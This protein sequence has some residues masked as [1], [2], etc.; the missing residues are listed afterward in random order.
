[1][2]TVNST[3]KVNGTS[4]ANNGTVIL[5]GGT[6]SYSSASFIHQIEA[7][8]N[9]GY[10]FNSWTRNDQGTVA[11]YEENSLKTSSTTASTK[12]KIK[13]TATI[14]A[15]STANPYTVKFDKNGGTG[16]TANASCTYDA[17]CK[18]T[19]NG[20]S[21]TGYNFLGWSKT[22]T[23]AVSYTNGQTVKNLATSGT[24]TL[25]AVWQLRVTPTISFS[26]SSK[27]SK[28]GASVTVTCTS[29]DGISSFTVDS[30]SVVSSSTTSTSESKKIDL[31]PSSQTVKASCT[32]NSS[33]SVSDSK[34]YSWSSS[35]DSCGTEKEYYDCTSGG[36]KCQGSKSSGYECKSSSG[37][38]CPSDQNYVCRKKKTCSRDVAK[39]CWH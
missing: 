18:L 34:K 38:G 11:F 2:K 9:T 8:A 23:G 1:M 4:V 20:Y 14:T 22:E 17:N 32:S 3:A 35:K 19:S 30:T 10:K 33:V 37:Y 13:N 7:T 39:T 28:N 31:S 6:G 12:I 15:T 26:L 16:T 5:L 24:V 36:Y 25:Y 27:T 29:S 21:R